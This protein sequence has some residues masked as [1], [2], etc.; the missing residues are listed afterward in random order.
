MCANLVGVTY[1]K[2]RNLD[3]DCGDAS[4]ELNCA[5]NCRCTRKEFIRIIS[6][7]DG[8]INYLDF[9]DKCSS[10]CDIQR[11]YQKFCPSCYISK[12]EKHI[13]MKQILFF[14]IVSLLANALFPT[15]YNLFISTTNHSFD[16]LLMTSFSS[17]SLSNFLPRIGSVKSLNQWKSLEARSGLLCG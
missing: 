1:D 15:L 2:V 6:K 7:C 8:T 17:L 4:N 14:N 12:T 16:M 11:A 13:I 5:N 3:D 9:S 10:D